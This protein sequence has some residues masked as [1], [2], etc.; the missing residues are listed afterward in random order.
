M[1][2]SSRS[3][4]SDG[5]HRPR[6]SQGA[7][8]NGHRVDKRPV[9]KQRV[10]NADDFP[11]LNGSLTP[12]SRSPGSNGSLPNGHPTAAQ[13][14]SAPPPFRRD[15][16]KESTPGNSSPE[17]VSTW[18]FIGSEKLILIHYFHYRR[19]QSLPS[20]LTDTSLTQV[21]KLQ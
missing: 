10:P 17:P 5:G 13:V 14:L 20:R 12:P 19:N 18:L 3:Q 4:S 8:A 16:T 7:K 6:P 2:S 1:D 21:M 11:V 9:S 15:G